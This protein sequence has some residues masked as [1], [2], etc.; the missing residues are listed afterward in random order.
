M[1]NTAQATSSGIG[2]FGLLTLIFVTLK[3]TGYITWSWFLVLL[4]IMPAIIL[5]GLTLVALVI[6]LVLTFGA[7][8][9]ASIKPRKKK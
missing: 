3:L 2:F 6:Y 1:S 4:P 5:I 7:A 8:V 9:L